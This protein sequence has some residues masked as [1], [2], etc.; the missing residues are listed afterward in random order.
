MS[1]NTIQKKAKSK[2]P[3]TFSNNYPNVPFDVITS[4]NYMDFVVNRK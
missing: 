2:S 1:L 4:E 3:L